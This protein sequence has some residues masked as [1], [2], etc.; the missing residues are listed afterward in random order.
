[1]KLARIV[2]IERFA[3]ALF[4]GTGRGYKSL[5]FCDGLVA[6]STTMLSSQTT[7]VAVVSRLS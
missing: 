7:S 4:S 1:M 6:S 2:P 3:T 5:L